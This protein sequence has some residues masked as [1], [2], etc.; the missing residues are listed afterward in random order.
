LTKATAKPYADRVR[1]KQRLDGLKNQGLP[2]GGAEPIPEGHLPRRM[3]QMEFPEGGEDQKIVPQEPPPG[4]GAA[5][6]VNQAMVG[7]ERPLT[8]REAQARA[9][10]NPRQG[11]ISPETQ[12][13]LEHAQQQAQEAEEEGTSVKDDLDKAEDE[14]MKEQ[15]FD[16]DFSSIA[17]AQNSLMDPKR[18]K[19]IEERLEPLDITDLITQREIIQDVPVIPG[20]LVFTFRTLSQREN[21]WCM[22]YVYDFPGSQRYVET[23]FDTAKLACVVM[24]LN[25]KPF[26]DHRKDIGQKGEDVDKEQFINKMGIIASWPVQ[27]IADAGIQCNWFNDRVNSLFN[28]GILKNG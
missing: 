5:Y 8:L 10:S 20:K 1:E 7:A 3:P 4:V 25:G 15:E 18:K 24:A 9:A 27:L 28:E 26:P 2:L 6:G 17:A 22:K 12:E 23:L 14:A 13:L 11:P 21:I 16:F 19:V